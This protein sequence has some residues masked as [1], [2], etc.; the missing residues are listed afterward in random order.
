MSLTITLP[1]N[2][3]K[4]FDSYITGHDLAKSIGK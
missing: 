3:N 2:S 4:E 1:D